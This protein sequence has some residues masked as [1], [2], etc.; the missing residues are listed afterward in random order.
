MRKIFPLLMPL[1]LY[2]I[3]AQAQGCIIIR[4]ISGFGQYNLADNLF[5][6]SNWQ[7]N[8]INRYFKAFREFKGVTDQKNP[9]PGIIHGFSTEVTLS[10]FLNKGWSFNVSLPINANSRSAITDHDNV[11]RHT[12]HSFG[13]GDI[14]ITVDKWLLNSSANQKGNIQVGLGL[15]LPTGDYK[16]Q[17]Y[18]YRNDSTKVLAPVSSSI[19]L[20]DG[21]TGI[22]TELNGFY[23]MNKRIN[24]Y[25]SFYYVINPRD[26]NGTS[27]T[28]GRTPTPLQVKT[29]NDVNSVPDLYSLRAGVSFHY[30]KITLSAGLRDEGIPVYD[31]LGGSNGFRRSGHNLSIEPGLV[32][33][34]KKVSIYAYVPV[35]VGRKIKQTVADKKET[36]ITGIYTVRPG[37]FGNYILFAGALFKL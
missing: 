10:K 32:Y 29:G 19:Q 7:V 11:H 14:R 20:G 34:M 35:I 28:F 27:P 31:L 6:A 8:I 3:F 12:T 16:Y 26:Q 33:I 36:E 1:L 23:R 37:G 2:N 15:K 5:S 25:G 30:K 13:L 18:F 4:N 22:I 21:G 17:D 9:E 24:F